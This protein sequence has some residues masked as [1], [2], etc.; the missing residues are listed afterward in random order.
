[1][2]KKIP[3]I[4]TEL[5]QSAVDVIDLINQKRFHPDLILLDISMPVMD[6][7]AFLDEFE[8]LNIPVPV[9]IVSSS[10]NPLDLARSK[11]YKS[12]AGFYCKPISSVDIQAM[13]DS[14]KV[15]QN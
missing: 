11:Q 6:G 1:I 13:V 14:F 9:Y 3:S 5:Y 10:I 12:V 15:N 4:K 7:W 2:A 8:K